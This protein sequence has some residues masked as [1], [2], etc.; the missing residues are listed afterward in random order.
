MSAYTCAKLVQHEA[1]L[2][3]HPVVEVVEHAAD[4]RV[5]GMEAIARHLFIDVVNLLAEVERE[6][7]RRER[8]EVQRGGPGAEQVVA[9]PGE[10]ADDD[11]NVLAT[12]GQLDAEQRF[13]RVV[14]GDLVH[15]RTDVVLAVDDRH[16]LVEVQM[17]AELLEARVQVA[18]VGRRLDDPLAVQFEDQ[19]QGR[20]RRRVLRAE[21]QRPGELLRLVAGGVSTSGSSSKFDGMV[22]HLNPGRHAGR[23]AARLVGVVVVVEVEP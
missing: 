18:D 2:G 6:Q 23:A 13:D 11:A 3:D 21:V 4:A 17:L 19:A 7:E 1:D 14:P 20:M 5:A 10:F 12:L 16:V 22:N 15:R 8:P 9:D